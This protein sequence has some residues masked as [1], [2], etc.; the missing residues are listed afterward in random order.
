MFTIADICN[1][2]TQIERNGETTYRRAS[3]ACRNPEIAATLT[4]IADQELQHARWFEVIRSTQSTTVEQQEVERMGRDLLQEMIRGNDFLL[5]RDDLERAG[6]IGEVLERSKLFE[7]DTILFYQF[8]LDLLND[9]QSV[10]W[11]KKIIQ[12]EHNHIRELERL[13]KSTVAI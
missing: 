5:S 6:S 8:L 13:E 10:S 12:E 7:Q 11:M 4:L 1:I 3:A 2:A 9:A